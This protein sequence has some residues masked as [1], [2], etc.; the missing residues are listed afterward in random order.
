MVNNYIFFLIFI[1]ANPQNAISTINDFSSVSWCGGGSPAAGTASVRCWCRAARTGTA[2]PALCRSQ[3]PGTASPP[4]SSPHSHDKYPDREEDH[5]H[6][7]AFLLAEICWIWTYLHSQRSSLDL[8]DALLDDEGDAVGTVAGH[9]QE[10]LPEQLK[11]TLELLVA[12]LNGQS[13]QA[14]LV[15]GQGTLPRASQTLKR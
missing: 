3:T 6:N 13:L 1:Y 4:A 8:A 2:P 10:I 7:P 9:L 14:A 5:Q 12:A 15:T 11:A